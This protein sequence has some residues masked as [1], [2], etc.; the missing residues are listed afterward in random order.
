MRLRGV[1]G[2]TRHVLCDKARVRHLEARADEAHEALVP[3][4]VHT[5]SQSGFKSKFANTNS[6]PC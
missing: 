6:V 1:E 3:E 5:D 2:A 4:V